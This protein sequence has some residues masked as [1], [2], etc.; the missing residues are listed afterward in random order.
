MASDPP[1]IEPSKK[2][3]EYTDEEPPKL[4]PDK[5][6]GAYCIALSLHNPWR[7]VN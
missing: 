5:T 1:R 7:I 2:N 4:N 6:W 3:S